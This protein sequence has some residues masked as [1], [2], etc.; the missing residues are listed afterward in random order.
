VID[1]DDLYM[2]FA[3]GL[4][5]MNDLGIQLYNQKRLIDDLRKKLSAP[6]DD[7]SYP[8]EITAHGFRQI[9]ERLE[10]IA[11]EESVIFS[12]VFNADPTKSLLVPSNLESFVFTTLAVARKSGKFTKEKSKSNQ[13]KLEYHYSVTIDKWSVGRKLEF[14]A[15]VEDNR[16]KTGYFNWTG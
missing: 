16:I 4:S 2:E 9:S 1:N 13:A 14:V 8:L 7:G 5:M 12:D 3:E 10:V 11:K 6:T 15:I